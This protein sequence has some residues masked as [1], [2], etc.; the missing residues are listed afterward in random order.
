MTYSRSAGAVTSLTFDGDEVEDREIFTVGMAEYHMRNVE[1][2]LGISTEELERNGRIRMI[3]AS[4][5]EILDEYLTAHPHLG[6][7][8]DGRIT[9]TD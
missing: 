6:H 9:V 8:V 7:S 4:C 5:R 1:K 3:A 2:G